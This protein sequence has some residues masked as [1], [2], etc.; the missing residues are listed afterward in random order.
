MRVARVTK[1][2]VAKKRGESMSGKRRVA[3]VLAILSVVGLIAS[4]SG[5]GDSAESEG[6]IELTFW[7][8]VENHADFMKE[9]AKAFNEATSGPDIT[10]KSTTSEYEQ[11]HEKLLVALQSGTG[12]PDL[13]DI[14]IAKF[15][16]FLHGEVQLH[17]LTEIVDRHRDQLVQERLAPYQS[18]GVQYGIDYH[19]GA[20]VMYYNTEILDQAGVDPNDIVTWDDYIEAGKTVKEK[21][22]KFMTTVENADRWSILGPMLQNGGGIYDENGESILDDPANAEAVQMV[23]D[24]VN[25]HGI[26]EIAPGSEHHAPEYLKRMNSGEYA[27]VWMPQ[28]YMIRFTDLMPDLEGKIIVRPLP[29]FEE[30]GAVTTM[31]GGTGTAI[32]KHIDEEKVDAAMDFLEFAKLTKEA[33]VKVWTDLGFDPWRTDVYDDPAL[34]GRD[35]WFGNEPVMKNISTMFD[36]LVPEYTGPRYPEAITLLNEEVAFSV[37]EGESATEQLSRAAEEINDLEN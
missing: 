19:L 17:D 27:S 29:A 8:F 35:P 11:H 9:Q 14:E 25:V 6:E 16:T 32:T 34:A 37:L 4:C 31:G 24:M 12:A 10:I 7:T 22:G 23:A 5:N 15:G 28:W 21:T 26:A 2:A 13:I 1:A 3:R 18:E 30:G 36:H 33:Q 20:F